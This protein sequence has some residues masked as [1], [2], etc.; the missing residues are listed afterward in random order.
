MENSTT[1]EIIER[2]EIVFDD[3]RLVVRL[4][5]KRRR[6]IVQ[7]IALPDNQEGGIPLLVDP[8]SFAK[9][10]QWL[11]DQADA[12]QAQIDNAPA[13]VSTSNGATPETLTNGHGEAPSD[14]TVRLPIPANAPQGGAF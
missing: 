6:Q 8:E 9:A 11:I 14:N 13:P 2:D 5:V 10:Y 12:Y 1:A 4:G 7:R 3:V